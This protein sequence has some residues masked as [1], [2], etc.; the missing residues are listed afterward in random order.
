M[1][2]CLSILLLLQVVYAPAQLFD[3][4]DEAFIKSKSQQFPLLLVFSGSDW[5]VPCI[6]FQN[7]IL[8]DAAFQSFAARQLVI[9]KTDF[10]QRKQ[11]SKELTEQN[12][13]LAEKY[14]PDGAFPQLVLLAIIPKN[15][16]LSIVN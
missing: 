3:K 15:H 14:N 13:R 7:T 11:L 2:I 6:R 1:K 9:L 8:N 12:E 10:P 5:C 4:A 16:I